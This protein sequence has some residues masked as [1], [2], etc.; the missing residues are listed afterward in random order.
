M[1][2]SITSVCSYIFE[3]PISGA[4][5]RI[6]QII[7]TL[8]FRGWNGIASSIINAEEVLPVLIIGQCMFSISLLCLSRI[9]NQEFI[10]QRNF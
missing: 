6:L 1:A 5:G 7:E 3:S 9:R 8:G 2:D 4:Q 10:K